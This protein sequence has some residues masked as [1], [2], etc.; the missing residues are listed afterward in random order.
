MNAGNS[1][2]TRVGGLLGAPFEDIKYAKI[3]LARGDPTE[4]VGGRVVGR[5]E[6]T[7][8][9][10]R[11]RGHEER[12]PDVNEWTLDEFRRV[13]KGQPRQLIEAQFDE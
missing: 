3:R 8:I 6:P 10:L 13:P 4:Y 5:F 2:I 1:E 11:Y 7:G 9:V 12:V